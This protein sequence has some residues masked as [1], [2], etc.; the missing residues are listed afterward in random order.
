M[1]FFFILLIGAFAAQKLL[2][3]MKLISSI[4]FFCNLFLQCHIQEIT[5]KSNHE[6]FLLFNVF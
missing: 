1:D 6:A 2:S 4:F 3:L 5:A